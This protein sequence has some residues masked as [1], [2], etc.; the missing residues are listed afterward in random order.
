MYSK[1]NCLTQTKIH[2]LKNSVL[3]YKT[4][5]SFHLSPALT[6]IHTPKRMTHLYIRIYCLSLNII[7]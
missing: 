1:E 4:K 2:K 5:L 6:N 7:I 3:E